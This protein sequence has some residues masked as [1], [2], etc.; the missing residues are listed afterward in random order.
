MGYAYRVQNAPVAST[1]SNGVESNTA[2]RPGGQ[3]SL[4]PQ[5]PSPLVEADIATFRTH[6]DKVTVPDREEVGNLEIEPV[7]TSLC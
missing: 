5:G 4:I 6:G 2:I 7:A 1:A 3:S